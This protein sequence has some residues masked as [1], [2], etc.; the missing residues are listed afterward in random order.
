[1]NNKVRILQIIPEFGLAGAEMMCESLIY[2]LKEQQNNEIIVVS[3]YD[4]HSAITK[5]LESNDVK[6]L[7]LNKKQGVD[8]SI[9]VK[10][11]KII[12]EYKIS[13]VHTHRYVMEYVIPAAIITGVKTRIH[14]VHSVAKE[15][16]GRFH[17]L[18]AKCFYKF[19]DVVPVA[20]S[21]LIK[22]TILEEYKL[23]KNKVYVVYNGIDLSRCKLKKS[24]CNDSI[25]RF[26]HVGRLIP[27]KNQELIIK[28]INILVN[29]GYNVSVSFLGAGEKEEYYKTLVKNLSL[30]ENVFFLGLK[31]DVCSLIDKYD[32]FLLPS[33]Y[34]G[35]PITLIEAMGTGLP[36]IASSVGGIPDMIEHEKE[37]LLIAP[38]LENLVDAMKRFINDKELR[39]LCGKNASIRVQMFSSDNMCKGYT[40]LYEKNKQK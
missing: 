40:K 24:Y 22:S 1:M 13:V 9:I 6:I 19:C 25:F 18:M 21:P 15:E 8:L 39:T 5:R 10:L 14:T 36:I 20:I 2:K 4:Y 26:V 7:Y 11:V 28:A 32:T 17:R 37:G 33:V 31:D 23:Q 35:M 38:Q 29:D 3:L 12:R 34:E 30:E 27:V 16:M